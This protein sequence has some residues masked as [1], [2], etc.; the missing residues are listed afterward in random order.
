MSLVR[1]FRERVLS[2]FCRACKKKYAEVGHG[3]GVRA[4]SSSR[5]QPH[6]HGIQ[7]PESRRSHS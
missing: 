1:H 4:R 2:E 7:L 3:R 6:L 5:I